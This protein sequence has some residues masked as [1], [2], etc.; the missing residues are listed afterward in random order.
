M[1][2]MLPCF[3]GNMELLKCDK[4]WSNLIDRYT[5][6]GCV[7]DVTQFPPPPAPR[8]RRQPPAWKMVWV[9]GQHWF[10]RFWPICQGLKFEHW[11]FTTCSRAIPVSMHGPAM[12]GLGWKSIAV[13][14][15]VVSRFLAR[16]FS[17]LSQAGRLVQPTAPGDSLWSVMGQETC[18]YRA[19]DSCVQRRQFTLT[20]SVRMAILSIP[21]C[22][23]VCVFVSFL[24]VFVFVFYT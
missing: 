6:L 9:D 10:S 24:F 22:V 19:G 1:Q 7:F 21:A 11:Q 13:L 15:R 5:T 2:S 3:P 20:L 23:Y 8:R 18:E 17:R 16:L 12:F 4:V 14:Y